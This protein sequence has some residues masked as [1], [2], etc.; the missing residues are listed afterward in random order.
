MRCTWENFRW[1]TAFLSLPSLWVW[2][3]NLIECSC[4]YLYS[5]RKLFLHN[6]TDFVLSHFRV[7]SVFKSPSM[8][9]LWGSELYSVWIDLRREFEGI[10]FL[11]FNIDDEAL[12]TAADVGSTHDAAWDWEFIFYCGNWLDIRYVGCGAMIHNRTLSKYHCFTSVHSIVVR[13]L[14][15]V[16]QRYEEQFVCQPE[17]NS[18]MIKS[19]KIRDKVANVRNITVLFA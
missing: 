4:G 5:T 2:H 19:W 18:H 8:N 7:C 6:T 13:I 11:F 1:R 10:I 12:E 17:N 14:H 16:V 3:V 15:A 9:P